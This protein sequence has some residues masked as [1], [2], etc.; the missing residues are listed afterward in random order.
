VPGLLPQQHRQHGV[1]QVQRAHVVHLLVLQRHVELEVGGAHGLVGAGAVHHQVEPAPG[2]DQALGG[3]MHRGAVGGVQRQCQAARVLAREGL[4]HGRAARRH[5]HA[6]AGGV[7]ARRGGAADA[8]G[9]AHQ[10]DAPALPF[11]DAG[12]QRHGAAYFL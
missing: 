9:R 10:P 3:G 12:V 1:E 5:G 8:G 7:Q 6:R 4:E 2:R 11:V